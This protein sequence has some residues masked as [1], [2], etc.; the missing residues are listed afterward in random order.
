MAALG[1]FET[2]REIPVSRRWEG[3]GVWR[4][5]S[6]ARLRACRPRFT[7]GGTVRLLARS[8]SCAG[9]SSASTVCKLL[10]YCRAIRRRSCGGSEMRARRS[11]TPIRR[12]SSSWATS[13]GAKPKTLA[14][15]SLAERRR[16][17][18]SLEKAGALI[19]VDE[20]PWRRWERGEW[21]P[22]NLTLPALDRLL[23]GSVKSLY[24]KDVR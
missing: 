10:R 9:E 16:R 12:S 17:G 11:S 14:E 23:G 22:T 8:S 15:A 6:R 2:S 20:G 24:L 18:L 19:E 5:P 3:S 4:T 21:K 7:R 13:R 1:A